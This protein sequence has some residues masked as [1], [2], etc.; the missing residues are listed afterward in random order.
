MRDQD[1]TEP[2]DP[3]PV[4]EV[5]SQLHHLLEGAGGDSSRDIELAHDDA[6]QYGA[7]VVGVD[8]DFDNDNLR[9]VVTHPATDKGLLVSQ[10]WYI[11]TPSNQ[12]VYESVEI[13][14]TYDERTKLAAYDEAVALWRNVV[15]EF[16]T[17]GKLTDVDEYLA[18]DRFT[19]AY[20]TM[21]KE[22]FHN[23]QRLR[24]TTPDSPQYVLLQ[25]ERR[26]Q[27]MNA[28]VKQQ[29]DLDDHLLSVFEKVGEVDYLTYKAKFETIMNTF[30]ARCN[31]FDDAGYRLADASKEANDRLETETSL[32]ATVEQ[33]WQLLKLL[34]R[35]QD[36]VV[37]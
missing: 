9:C 15:R 24:A 29:H 31:V 20:V 16:D 33:S 18:V 1:P 28:Q 13:P 27:Y 37:E 4:R 26:V 3:R 12:M 19:S 10:D 14:F 21:R 30:I 2:T 35:C 25:E 36:Y 7:A 8:V 11:I 5:R 23:T 34:D 32:P 22:F 17:A 6:K